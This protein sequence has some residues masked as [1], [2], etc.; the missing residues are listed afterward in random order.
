MRYDVF[1]CHASEDKD[2][3]ARPLAE[4]LESRGRTVWL[5]E[6]Q[7]TVGD[8]LRQRIDV[9]LRESRFGIVILSPAFF[10]KRWPQ[11]ELDGLAQREMLSGEKVVLPVWHR[12]TA[13]DV[14]AQ[15][16][17]L[18]GRLAARTDDGLDA[19]AT[20]IEAV[21]AVAPPDP[22][23]EQ[24]GSPPPVPAGQHPVLVLAP[25]SQH[26]LNEPHRVTPEP[27]VI[28]AQTAF[29]DIENVGSATAFIRGSGADTCSVGTVTVRAPSAVAASTSRPVEL[30]VSTMTSN[31]QLPAGEQLR[32][33]LDYGVGDEATRRLW[34]TARY[35]AGGGW[36][37]LSSESRSLA[38][39]RKSIHE[40]A[41]AA[42]ETERVLA[43]MAF[44][45]SELRGG[46]AELKLR[47][48]AA[49][50][51]EEQLRCIVEAYGQSHRSDVA[52][53]Q[54]GGGWLEYA[55]RFP[56]DFSGAGT[57]AGS[58]RVTWRA[59]ESDE[60]LAADEFRFP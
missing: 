19:V 11:W 16:P 41:S 56:E 9:G 17:S 36:E 4:V 55:T 58:H 14:A 34:A 28:W 26:R 60:E 59:G 39:P 42:G 27:Q 49:A 33:W 40:G 43:R 23:E 8:S 18:A 38:D 3:V 47:R 7:L 20:E 46:S 54:V 29:V 13:A 21:F 35:N 53:T 31:M 5:D 22:R 15:S 2:D 57:M 12:V 32:F 1:V 24:V 30:V 50:F 48:W 45:S 37:N 6:R 25:P 44:A 10:A 51:G 52:P